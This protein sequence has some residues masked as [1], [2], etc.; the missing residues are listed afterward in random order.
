MARIEVM[1]NGK[2]ASGAE[3]EVIST[4]GFSKYYQSATTDRNGEANLK[5]NLNRFY[6]D[7]DGRRADTVDQLRGTIRI[8]L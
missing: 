3:V 5:D 6:V 8:S 7:V 4:F 1:R 2:P